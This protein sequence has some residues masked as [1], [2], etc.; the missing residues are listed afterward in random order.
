MIYALQEKPEEFGLP[1][2]VPLN[3]VTG[4]QVWKWLGG[5]VPGFFVLA[6]LWK[7]VVREEETH[8]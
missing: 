5:L 7:R 4:Q 1:V 6:W 3:T 2:P 8:G